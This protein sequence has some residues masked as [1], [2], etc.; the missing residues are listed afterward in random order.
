MR[1][2][3][4]T[5]ATTRLCVPVDSRSSSSCDAMSSV[6][7]SVSAACARHAGSARVRF[8]KRSGRRGRAVPAPQQ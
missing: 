5:A 1:F 4:V 2:R 8:K 3:S 6:V 7:F